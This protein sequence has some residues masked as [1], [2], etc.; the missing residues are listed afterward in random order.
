MA[1]THHLV[2]EIGRLNA[3]ERRI[4]DQFIHRRRQPAPEEATE[5]FGDRVADRVTA[6]GGSWGFIFFTIGA[7]AAWMIANAAMAKA[8]DAYPYILLNLVLACMTV[9][10]APLIMMSQNRQ[11]ARDRL[12]AQHDYEVNTKAEM[13][14][15]A[16]QAKLDELRDGQWSELLKAQEQQLALLTALTSRV[17]ASATP[18]AGG[19]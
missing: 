15:A 10:Q 8:F 1:D 5:S 19:E 13:E 11:A 12:D 18:S 2:A 14:I 7:I 9:L 6:F 16:L 17:E 4:I 3:V